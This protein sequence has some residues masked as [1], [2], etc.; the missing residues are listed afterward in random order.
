MQPKARRPGFVTTEEFFGQPQLLL[1]P[2]EKIGAGKFLGRLRLTLIQLAR[3]H[4]KTSMY[5]DAD[6][7]DSA[8]ANGGLGRFIGFVSFVHR[9]VGVPLERCACQFSSCHLP[10]SGSGR[11][12]LT[13]FAVSNVGIGFCHWLSSRPRSALE[14]LESRVAESLLEKRAVTRT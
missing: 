9:L 10:K 8:L 5:I 12:H 7:H 4:D 1:H 14:Q 3:G 2:F 11:E 13:G 6:L